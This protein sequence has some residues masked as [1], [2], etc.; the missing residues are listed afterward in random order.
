[1]YFHFR[2]LRSS[3]SNKVTRVHKVLT[4]ANSISL[5]SNILVVFLELIPVD[6]AEI[7]HMKHTT[8]FVPVTEPAR[9]PGSDEEALNDELD[10]HNEKIF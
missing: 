7:S 1:M 8:E 10:E 2:S 9:L 3:F 6:R 5:F 4:V